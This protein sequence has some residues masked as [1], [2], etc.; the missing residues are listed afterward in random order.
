MKRSAVIGVV[1]AATAIV[2]GGGVGWWALTRAPS[3]EDAALRYVN[4]LAAGDYETISAMGDPTI[5]APLENELRLAFEGAAEYLSNPHIDSIDTEVDGKARVSTTIELQGDQLPMTF[6]LVQSDTGEWRLGPRSTGSLEIT[7]TLGDSV[8]VGDALVSASTPVAL[9]PAVYKVAPAPGGLLAGEAQAAVTT[10]SQT[11]VVEASLSPDATASAQ[12]QL[13]TYA[14]ACTQPAVEVADHCG[15]R[16]PWAADLT[17][18]TNIVYRVEQHPF[19]TL[20]D[21][22]STFTATDGVVVATAT[23]TTWTG[24]AGT[25]TYQATDWTLSGSV[26]FQG[27]EMVLSVR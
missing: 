11:I 8:L 12:Q 16:V 22:G 25:F 1:A 14:D 2:I 3:T 19:V 5:G 4:A 6:E 18:L 26:R 9:L 23:G 13:D 15:L 27:N 7:T 10:D 17:T 24:A 20:A 21:D